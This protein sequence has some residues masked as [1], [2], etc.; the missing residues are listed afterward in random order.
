MDDALHPIALRF[1]RA[2][3]REVPELGPGRQLTSV[4]ADDDTTPTAVA[5]RIARRV[6]DGVLARQLVGDLAVDLGEVEHLIGEEGA[7]AG[8]LRELPQGELGFF[9]ALAL[10][11]V[12]AAQADRVDRGFRTLGQIEHFFERQQA[13]GVFL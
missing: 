3:R 8:F 10:G 6:A 4:D 11:R 13:R 9:E 2:R 1:Y 7:P 12:G 5:S